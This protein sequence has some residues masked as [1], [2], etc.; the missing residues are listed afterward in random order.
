MHVHFPEGAIPKDGPSAGIA[1]ATALVSALT[2]LPVRHDVAMT[3]EITL[4]EALVGADIPVVVLIN[5]FSA[6][7]SE[8]VSGAL[9]DHERAV[10]VGQRS[11]GKGSVQNLIPVRGERDDRFED[12]NG[13]GRFDNWETITRSAP[14]IT[15]VPRRVIMGSSPM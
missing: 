2:R 11:F 5:R 1:I 4:R 6:S 10:L 12:E 7:A 13:N 8:I 9:Q 15:K 3:G 14:L